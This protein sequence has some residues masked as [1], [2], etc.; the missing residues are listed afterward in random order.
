MLLY[1]KIL[2]VC[3][4]CVLDLASFTLRKSYNPRYNENLFV[5]NITDGGLLTLH[6]FNDYGIW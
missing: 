5:K 6:R 2:C 1:N 4:Y 3:H